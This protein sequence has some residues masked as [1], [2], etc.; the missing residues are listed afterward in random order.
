MILYFPHLLLLVLFFVIEIQKIK[1]F[2]DISYLSLSL[3]LSLDAPLMFLHGELKSK[4]YKKNFE[5]I[6]SSNFIYFFVA[7]CEHIQ[8]SFPNTE[9][10]SLVHFR[11]VLHILFFQSSLIPIKVRLMS[12]GAK[13]LSA[14]HH[15]VEN[16]AK[17]DCYEHNAFL[18]FE[19]MKRILSK[20][21]PKFTDWRL[22]PLI[23]LHYG[24]QVCVVRNSHY[25]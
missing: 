6:N 4:I 17:D 10:S 5:V 18:H 22:F 16:V 25:C 11:H 20:E 8:H 19:S 13:M 14:P 2:D 1:T 12:T 21:E 7:I 15:V 24:P 23:F 9:Q 3:K